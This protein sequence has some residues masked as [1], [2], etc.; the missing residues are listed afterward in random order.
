M[1]SLQGFNCLQDQEGIIFLMC[2]LASWL[3]I[4]AVADHAV[5]AEMLPTLNVMLCPSCSSCQSCGRGD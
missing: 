5:T 3:L 2:N 4:C 1:F